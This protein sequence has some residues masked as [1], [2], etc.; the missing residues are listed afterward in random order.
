MNT[1]TQKSKRPKPEDFLYKP[2]NMAL[3]EEKITF[4]LSFTL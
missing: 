1:P 4:V 3:S 2:G